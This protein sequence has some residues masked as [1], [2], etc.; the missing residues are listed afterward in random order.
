MGRESDDGDWAGAGAGAGA[1]GVCSG[2]D[3]TGEVTLAVAAVASDPVA[4]ELGVRE[5]GA[6]EL[7]ATGSAK[8]DVLAVGELF[9][10]MLAMAVFKPETWEGPG[11]LIGWLTLVE[12][13]MISFPWTTKLSLDF[14]KSRVSISG[15]DFRGCWS[16]QNT[17]RTMTIEAKVQNIAD[18]DVDDTKEPLVPSLELALIEYLNGD[19]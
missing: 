1:A 2:E 6:V 13:Y 10:P 19:D 11:L 3:A 9:N 17:P 18:S 12:R 8:L 15:R 14:F 16:R 4:W 5:S 7:E